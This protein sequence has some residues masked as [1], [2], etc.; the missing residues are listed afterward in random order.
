[1]TDLNRLK[2]SLTKHNAHKVARLLKD[3]PAADVFDRLGQVRAEAA[4][5]RNNLSTLESD[6]L[7][8]VWSKVQALGPDAID[9]LVFVAIIFS[10]RDLIKAMSQASARAGHIGRIERNRQLS[11]KA[12]TNFVRVTDQLG[13]A[14]KVEHDGVT[15]DLR[16]M[17]QI[18]GLGPL[19]GE[20]LELKLL[21]ANWDRSNL[22]PQEAV[23]LKLEQVFGLSASE[24]ERWISLGARPPSAEPALTT[25][26]QA[27]FED[28]AE[29]RAPRKFKFR[30]GHVDRDVD[31][32]Q[33]SASAK[34]KANRLHNDVQNRLYSFLKSKLGSKSV[35][36][37]IDTGTG[38]AIDVVTQHK[39]K[40][41][42]YEIKTAPSVRASIRQALPQLL[43]YAFWPQ[44]RRAD[45]L[46]VV[47]HLPP[48][49]AAKKYISFLR[50]E[51]G[52]PI[53]YKQ[54]DL[55]TNSLK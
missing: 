33:R 13:Y 18:P 15:F 39:G 7:P 28:A 11:G 27:Y 41:T 16:G 55:T 34:S 12:Y 37:E 51:F 29:G 22:L 17:F 23:R 38:T 2:V 21:K 45:E 4:Q 42:F 10:H 25:K 32:V 43:E 47:S 46:I 44:E 8:P 49:D 50:S 40:T 6:A 26:D 31:P 48:T 20:L 36:T 30:A 52:L 1:M 53:S 24:F 9:A 3:Y 5:A 14:T 35:G 19:V 54:F